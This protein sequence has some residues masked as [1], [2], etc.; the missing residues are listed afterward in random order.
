MTD[1]GRF[2][3][4]VPVVPGG[5]LSEYLGSLRPGAEVAFRGP[6]GRSMVP[7]DLDRDLVLVATGVGVGPLCSL[8]SHLLVRGF[9]RP[10]ELFWGLRLAEDICLTEELDRLALEHPN[11]SYRI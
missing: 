1:L 11:F 5:P 9:E 6:A 3:L 8:A 2:E 4:L 7:K 10:I